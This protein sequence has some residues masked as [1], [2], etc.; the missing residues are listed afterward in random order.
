MPIFSRSQG[1]SQPRRCGGAPTSGTWARRWVRTKCLPFRRGVTQEFLNVLNTKSCILMYS[2]APKIGTASVFIETP[3]QFGH[4]K[5]ITYISCY[6]S[7]SADDSYMVV[8]L[9]K[10]DLFPCRVGDLEWIPYMRTPF[11]TFNHCS[12]LKARC[13]NQCRC[14]K[15]RVRETAFSTVYSVKTFLSKSISVLKVYR[16]K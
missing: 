11:P 2:L 9:E 6:P 14:D 10:L 1:R 13:T 12:A 16:L 4:T 8:F 5:F 7:E 3:K 15:H